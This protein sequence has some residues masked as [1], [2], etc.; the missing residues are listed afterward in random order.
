MQTARWDRVAARPLGRWPNGSRTVRSRR[1]DSGCHIRMAP[2]SVPGGQQRGLRGHRRQRGDLGRSP[3][4][5]RAGRLPGGG[6]QEPYHAVAATCRH[7][8]HRLTCQ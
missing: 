8:R 2:S 4:L 5:Q 1:P 7:D 6:V 3:V